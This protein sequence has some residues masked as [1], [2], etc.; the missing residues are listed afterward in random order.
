[1]VLN[2]GSVV[3]KLRAILNAQDDAEL[4]LFLKKDNNFDVA[5]D[6]M[7]NDIR[8]IPA[9]VPYIDEERLMRLTHDIPAIR[10]FVTK[11]ENIDQYADMLNAVLK[12]GTLET[13]EETRIRALLDRGVRSVKQ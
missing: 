12:S 6:L 13:K 10:E 9:I 8:T 5:A 4:M 11:F 1:M 7:R 2:S 3:D